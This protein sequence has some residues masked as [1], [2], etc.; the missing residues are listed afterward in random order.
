MLRRRELQG[1]ATGTTAAVDTGKYAPEQ[2]ERIYDEMLRSAEHLFAGGRGAVLDGT[3]IEARH[4]APVIAFA[5][6]Q[7]RRLHVVE[8]QAPDAVIAERQ[9]IRQEQRWTTSEGRWD[10]YV[11]Q[12][13]RYEPPSEVPSEERIIVDTTQPLAE[14]IEAVIRRAGRK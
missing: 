13:E 7:G 8:C 10:V 9:N 1:E 12:K 11:A 14:Q 2:R 4:R 3:Y 5:R 6:R